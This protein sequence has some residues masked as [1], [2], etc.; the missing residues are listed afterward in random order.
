MIEKKE[1]QEGDQTKLEPD[2]HNSESLGDRPKIDS[3]SLSFHG[4]NDAFFLNLHV[5]A[6]KNPP[7][8]LPT[9]GHCSFFD[10]SSF[11]I[12]PLQSIGFWLFYCSVSLMVLSSGN[13]I[14]ENKSRLTLQ[15]RKLQGTKMVSFWMENFFVVKFDKVNENPKM[16]SKNDERLGLQSKICNFDFEFVFFRASFLSLKLVVEIGILLSDLVFQL[17]SIYLHDNFSYEPNSK[18]VIFYQALFR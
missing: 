12:I 5:A 16:K 2:R 10:S 7:P 8:D 13:K 4:P 6:T 3:P 14:R 1:P 11:F 15:F 17:T 18:W 9:K